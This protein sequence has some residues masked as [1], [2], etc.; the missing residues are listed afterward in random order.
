MP[1]YGID[2]AAPLGTQVISVGDG[3][4]IE[5]RYRG[6]NGNIVKIKHNSTYT[7]AYLHLNGFARGIRP[8]TKVKQGQTIGYVG[9]TGRVTGVHLDYRIY[10]NNQP[11]NPLNIEIPSSEALKD[12]D[13]ASFKLYIERYKHLMRHSNDEMLA[14][15][16]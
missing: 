12:E 4:V 3:V 15:Y 10:K 13:L 2:Y 6:A 9:R 7:T 14:Q 5:A 1:H 8:G 11:V 16:F